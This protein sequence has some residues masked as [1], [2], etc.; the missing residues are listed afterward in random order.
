MKEIEKLKEEYPLLNKLIETEEVLWVNPNMEKYETAIKDSPLSEEN[1]KD[2]KERL[3][4]FASYI[5]KVFPETKETKGIIESPLLKIPSMKQAL[6]KNYEQPILGELLLKCDSHLPISG[7]IKARGGIYEVLKH[8]EQLALQHGMLTEEDDYSILD[9]DTCREF[10]AKYSIAVGSTGNLGL[11]IGIMSAKL[12]FNV[13]VH[14]SAD[15]KQWKKDLLRSKGVN[16]IEY[17]ADYSKAVEE[18]RQQADAD[19]SCYFVD[20]ENSHDLFLGY[21]VA[22]SRLQKQLEELEIIV[23]EEHPLFVYL[24][25][26]VGGGPGGVAFGL[27]LLYKDN[28]HCFFAEPTHSPC[29]LIGLMTGLHDKIAVQDIGIDNVTDADGL[30][31]GRPSGFVGKTMEPF[32][33]GDYTVSDEELYR[34]LKELADTENIYLEPSAL[35]GMIG[36]V[37]V[38]KEDAYLQKQQLMEKMQKGTHIVWGTGGSMVPEDV[39]NGYYKTGE[40]LTILEK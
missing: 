9:S 33:S 22:A 4:R 25:C 17:E 11:S 39:M 31:V 5:A 32:L 36:P 35:A 37:R 19:P 14:M 30:A 20:D 26:G 10:F 18:G 8:A 21:A 23:D 1:V 2:A 34:L 13:T 28:V 3:K 38:C 7:S 29:M 15:A 27:K 40:A 16:V 12:G 24:P 6:E